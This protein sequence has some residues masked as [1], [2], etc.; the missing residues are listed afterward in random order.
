MSRVSG[1]GMPLHRS[2]IRSRPPLNCLEIGRRH[3]IKFVDCFIDSIFDSFWRL[4]PEVDELR[5]GVIEETKNSSR[6]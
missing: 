1:Q 2:S 5:V 6:V 3:A 4:A